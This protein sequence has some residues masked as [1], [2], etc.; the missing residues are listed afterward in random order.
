MVSFPIATWQTNKQ[1]VIIIRHLIIERTLPSSSDI[2]RLVN[3]YKL[4]LPP[5]QRQPTTPPAHQRQLSTPNPS[6]LQSL[7]P[8]HPPS[9][10]QAANTS[11]PPHSHHPSTPKPST[12]HPP[13]PPPSQPSPGAPTPRSAA[14][15]TDTSAA[16]SCPAQ[17]FVRPLRPSFVLWRLCRRVR[18]L[19]RGG[20]ARRLV[21]RERG[22]AVLVG[23]GRKG[24]IVSLVLVLRLRCSVWRV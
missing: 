15:D 3:R 4:T 18:K 8:S 20:A 17:H 7:Q 14:A 21:V 6:P 9:P 5:T 23:G 16:V 11:L 13:S 22:E 2:G 1:H 19:R 10:P 12:P 24:G